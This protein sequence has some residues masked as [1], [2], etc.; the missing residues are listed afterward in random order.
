MEEFKEGPHMQFYEAMASFA[1]EGDDPGLSSWNE[2]QAQASATAREAFPDH[3][4]LV[5]A[6]GLDWER[7]HSE[8]WKELMNALHGQGWRKRLRLAPS[9]AA[10]S[11]ARAD[12][13][14]GAAPVSGAGAE[15]PRSRA[16]QPWSRRRRFGSP[17]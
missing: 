14:D 13:V 3:K 10:L 5:Q 17:V 4:A 7:Y 12:P 1:A 11:A 15:G 16:L 8:M 9:V 2:W 6:L